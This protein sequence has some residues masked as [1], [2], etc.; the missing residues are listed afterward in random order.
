[1]FQGFVGL[2][3]EDCLCFLSYP[4]GVSLMT[5][6]LLTQLWVS[7]RLEVKLYDYLRIEQRLV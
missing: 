2:S 6:I 1:M 4:P 3:I 5:F 7:D